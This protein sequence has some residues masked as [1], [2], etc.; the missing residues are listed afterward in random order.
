MIRRP[1]RSTLFPYTTLF[2]SR[3]GVHAEPVVEPPGGLGTEA[4]DLEEGQEGRREAAAQLVE[5]REATR[6][7]VLP[8]LRRELAPDPG[9]CASSP[10]AATAS[11]L[12]PSVSSVCAARA[13]ARTRKTD[14]FRTSR[15]RAISSKRRAISRFFTGS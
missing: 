4:T 11:T 13:Y 14:S 1:P 6:R 3:D 9:S 2:R 10:R 12:S 5:L 8:D 15:R 7:Q